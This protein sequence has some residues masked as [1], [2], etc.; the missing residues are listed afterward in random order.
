M[1]MPLG[2]AAACGLLALSLMAASAAQA[3]PKASPAEL[4]AQ[5]ARSQALNAEV[6]RRNAEIQAHND[7]VRSAYAETLADHRRAVL[8]TQAA[9]T[10]YDSKLTENDADTAAYHEQIERW[11]KRLAACQAHDDAGCRDAS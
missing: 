11:R 10:D 3:A 1:S 4:E 9:R 8:A 2:T 7:A 5:N 6:N